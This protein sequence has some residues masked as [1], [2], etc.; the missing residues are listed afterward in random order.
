MVSQ[1]DPTDH[2]LAA[3]ASILDQPESNREPEKSAVEEKPVA[4]ERM[5]ADGYW[6]VGPGPMAAIRFKWTVR[7]EDDGV[8]YVDETIGENSQPIVSGPMSAD[9]AIRF[10]DDRENEA[11]QR[12]EQLKS[13]MIGRGSAADLVRK[14][15][16]EI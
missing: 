16:G 9:A 10:V 8:Y 14:D 15:D 5:E 6:K 12:F 11:R 4:P 7:R 3:I 1:S 2:A 13:E